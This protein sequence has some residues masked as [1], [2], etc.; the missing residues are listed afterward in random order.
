MFTQP[1]LRA[2]GTFRSLANE[3]M[4]FLRAYD[5]RRKWIDTLCGSL[6]SPNVDLSTGVNQNGWQWCLFSWP[7][8]I[9]YLTIGLEEPLGDPQGHFS[10]SDTDPVTLK[11]AKTFPAGWKNLPQELVDKILAYLEDNFR[12]LVSCS[13]SCKALFCSTRPLIHRTLCLS[14]GHLTDRHRSCRLNRAQLDN[15]RLAERAQVLQYTTLLI[16]RLG[17][18]FVPGNLRPYLQYFR[19]MR[20]ITSL[21]ISRL[22]A[23]SFPRFL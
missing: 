2:A 21:Q 3:P 8:T 10:T 14:T 5:G 13:K 1:C 16:I 23:A 17:L 15:L 9:S 6:L 18:D 4:D 19:T 22:D 12:S 7:G 11:I 20:T